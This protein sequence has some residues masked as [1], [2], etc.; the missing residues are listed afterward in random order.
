MISPHPFW[1]AHSHSLYMI[2]CPYGSSSTHLHKTKPSWRKLTQVVV[3]ALS[4]CSPLEMHPIPIHHSREVRKVKNANHNVAKT[5]LRV[6]CL[7]D[8]PVASFGICSSPPLLSQTVSHFRLRSY[9]PMGR[10]IR[11]SALGYIRRG[12]TAIRETRMT[13]STCVQSLLKETRRGKE[14]ARL[15]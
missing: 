6:D 14:I 10:R 15:P 13:C 1:T 3:M 8:T 5:P 2:D 12:L 7:P 11:S 9:Q 4:S